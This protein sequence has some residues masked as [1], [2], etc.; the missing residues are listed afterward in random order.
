M[1]KKRVLFHTDGSFANTGFGRNIKTL[2][3]HLYQ[4]N[5]YDI[6]HYC[7]N[8]PYSHPDCNRTPWTTVGCLPNTQEEINNYMNQF[9]PEE[10]EGRFREM[11]Y[12]SYYLDR[13]I[14]ENKPD[15]YFAIQDIWG[16]NFGIGRKWFRDMTSVIWTTLDSLPI[17]PTAVE[18]AP[19]IKN[20]WIWSE[21]ATKALHQLGHKHV[22][23]VHGAIDTKYFFKLQNEQ[24][25]KLR[26]QHNIS[27]E[28]FVVGFVF[29]NQLRK[30]VPNLLEGYKL[31]REQNK[32]I[33]S[34][35]L[36]HT[37]FGEGWNIHRLADE[38]GLDKSEIL[39]TYVCRACHNFQVKCFTGMNIDCPLCGAKQ[40][41]ITTNVG[42]GVTEEQ[43]N[44]VYNLM[45]VYCHPFTSG[46]QEIPIEEAKL[47]ELVT[48][49]TNYSCG[50][51]LCSPEA[52]S[53]PLEWTE[54]R[55]HGTEF[56]K[57]S[58]T[59]E[60]I[61]KQ[62]SL[63][64]RTPLATRAA[65]G[66]Q[67]RKWTL[68]NYSTEA[69]SKIIQETIDNAPF[70]ED[71]E[72]FNLDRNPQASIG[73]VENDIDWLKKLYGEILKMNVTDKDGGLQHWLG[74]MKNGEKREGIENYF[75][76]VAHQENLKNKG[77]D[78]ES[79][80][81][82]NDK[83]KRI[84]VV[85][86]ESIGDVFMIT[87]LFP[88]LK[89]VYP[90]YSL[91]VATKQE[92]FEVFDMNPHIKKVIAYVPQMDS[93]LWLEGQWTHNGFFEIAFLPFV[94]TQRFF[95]YQHNG[96]DKIEYDL[97]ARMIKWEANPKHEKEEPLC[98]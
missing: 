98:T 79:W 75:R 1:R 54:Y 20:Y 27:K 91:Y 46:G 26:E 36:L 86:P 80:L 71:E 40:S 51:E 16:I 10:R 62:L 9:R 22:K 12:G 32:Q 11:C 25:I 87:S 31:F 18:S 4:T 29:R 48:L 76:Q 97:N 77:F 95:D 93:L 56:R 66:Q 24:R 69:I 8:T 30:S 41:Q 64:M 72:V 47:C 94:G 39:T 89:R 45:D 63:V 78:L 35:L 55:E 14:K 88:S 50:E 67:A 73:F 68:E 65:W 58:T 42:E 19:L 90:E 84:L 34:K 2:L 28:T 37:H 33:N 15:V 60:S 6:V 7:M 85:I 13:A 83:G 44:L 3:K 17:L 53:L 96:K 21:F 52:K 5:K 23:T 49:V 59:P 81:D 92:Y 43:L 70:V 61:A 38:Y 57:A 82:P 74:R